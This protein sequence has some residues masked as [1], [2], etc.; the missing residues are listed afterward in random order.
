MSSNRRPAGQAKEELFRGVTDGDWEGEIDHALD[1]LL[2]RELD[3]KSSR[4]MTGNTGWSCPDTGK[5][6]R[7]PFGD[8]PPTEEIQKAIRGNPKV[9]PAEEPALEITTDDIDQAVAVI[10]EVYENTGVGD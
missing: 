2:L 5:I 10:D 7:D 4:R 9:E 8:E 6:L 3:P 1:H